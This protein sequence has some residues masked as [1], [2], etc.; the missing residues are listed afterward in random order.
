MP[1]TLNLDGQTCTKYGDSV[2]FIGDATL[3]EFDSFWSGK[4]RCLANVGG[5]LASLEITVHFPEISW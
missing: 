1:K 3:V 5:L 2:I 4:Y